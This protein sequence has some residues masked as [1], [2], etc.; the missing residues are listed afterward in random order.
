MYCVCWHDL[1]LIQG[2]GQGAFELPT[3][4]HN[5]TFLCLS[6]PPF[7]QLA[8]PCMLAAM[9]AA[10]LRGFLVGPCLFWP[11]GWMDQD[12]SW[13]RGRSWPRQHCVCVAVSCV[14]CQLSSCDWRAA[15]S[16]TW[17]RRW[18]SAGRVGDL[19]QS[20]GRHQGQMMTSW[21]MTGLRLYHSN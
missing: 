18:R 2:Q 14:C 7:R 3:I 10:P 15:W 11:N 21:W 1:D 9:T 20:P 8:K 12:A 4:A 19:L 13:Y 16:F 6:P 17:R 5:C